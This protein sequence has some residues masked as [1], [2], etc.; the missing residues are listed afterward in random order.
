MIK[1][2]VSDMDGTLLNNGGIS[3]GN[4]KAIDRLKDNGITFAI[5]SGRDYQGV[6][7]VI[8]NYDIKCEAILGNGAQYVDETGK[9]IM[10]CYMDKGIVKDVIKVFESNHAP[11]MIFTTSGFY[12]T[13]DI[14]WVRKEFIERGIRRFHDTYEDFEEGGQFAK[15]PANHLKLIV[16]LDEFLTSKRD[17]I[18]IETFALTSKQIANI[19]KSLQHIPSICYLSS[20][21]DNIE[22]T[23]Y[24][25]QKGFILEKVIE[26]KGLKKEEVAVLGDGMNDLSM[27]QCFPY[28]FAMGNAEQTI[29]DL[30]YQVVCDHKE[31]GV[32]QAIDMILRDLGH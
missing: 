9:M 32:A 16:D 4:Q 21:D 5:A 2:V 30:A 10:N 13:Q 14:S 28:S 20:F 15:A 19:K 12:T 27:F 11:Y 25:A 23:D 31:D 22:V 7:S 6:Y 29:K 3:L 24:Y 17:I 18:K 8:H 1:F 26:L